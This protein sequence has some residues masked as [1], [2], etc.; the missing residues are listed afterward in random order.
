MLLLVL[1]HG[2]EV[3]LIQ[4]DVRR[5]EG[6]VGEEAAVYIVGVFRALVLELGHAAQLPEHGV[7]VEDPAE[8]GMLVHMALQEE[9]VLLRVEAAGDVL[10]QLRGGAAAQLLRVLPH[11]QGVQ[12][13]HEVKAVEL[14][15]QLRPVF[16]RAQVVAQVQVAG[17][18]DAGEHDFLLDVFVIH[19]V[20]PVPVNTN[21]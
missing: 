4:Q 11:G 15:G 1:A 21:P 9:G 2:D 13:G 10:G 3:R 8:L 6:G 14:L 20:S 18:L 12:V 19:K 5:H 7:A 17:G 16:H